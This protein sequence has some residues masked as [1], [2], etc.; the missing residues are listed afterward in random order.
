MSYSVTNNYY[1]F[2]K[3]IRLKCLNG[4]NIYYKDNILI[5]KFIETVKKYY[6]Y[7]KEQKCD[8]NS[9]YL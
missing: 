7:G 8:K 6:E 2:N 1:T 5:L 9:K 4:I 3:I